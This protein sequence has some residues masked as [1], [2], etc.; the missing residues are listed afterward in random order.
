M[1]LWTVHE[2]H[3]FFAILHWATLLF[4]CWTICP[5]SCSQIGKLTKSLLVSQWAFQDYPFVSHHETIICAILRVFLSIPQISLSSTALSQ[6]FWE[7]LWA[8][9]SEWVYSL[10]AVSIEYM[11]KMAISIL[12][13]SVLFTFYKTPQFFEFV[14]GYKVDISQKMETNYS[15]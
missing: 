5:W 15:I 2:I 11:P 13:N 3:K 12:S 4:N 10:C 9:N 14:G 8:L 7:V 1:V 6:F